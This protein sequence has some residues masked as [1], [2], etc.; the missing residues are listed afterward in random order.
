MARTPLNSNEANFSEEEL[1]LEL[2]HRKKDWI[3]MQKN[4]LSL[5]KK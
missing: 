3:Y 1:E 4:S 2:Q 5:A